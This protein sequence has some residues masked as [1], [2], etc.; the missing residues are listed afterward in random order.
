MAANL[1]APP[2][3]LRVATPRGSLAYWELTPRV[4]LTEVR[5]FM[6]RDMARLIID[7]AGLMFARQPRVHGFHNWLQMNNYESAC[8][9]DLTAWVL[10]HRAQSVLHIGVASRMVAMGVAVANLALGDL[11]HVHA[12]AESLDAALGATLRSER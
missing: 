9:V 12:D 6:T 5:G 4:Y 8:R 2:S 1:V 11:I 10:R 7:R 3:A